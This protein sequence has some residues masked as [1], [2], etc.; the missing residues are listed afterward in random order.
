VN[1]PLLSGDRHLPSLLGLMEVEEHLATEDWPCCGSSVPTLDGH[2]EN[3]RIVE[4][5]D[6]YGL[7]LDK[8]G[9]PMVSYGLPSEDRSSIWLFLSF[10]SDI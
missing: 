10:A 7:P 5:Y 4:M 3:S 8:H 9:K 6:S 2:G 1:H